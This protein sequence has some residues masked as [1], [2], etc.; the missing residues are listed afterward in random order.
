MIL[1][2]FL[3]SATHHFKWLTSAN[4]WQL[5]K[6]HSIECW[7]VACIVI[8]LSNAI[9]WARKKNTWTDKQTIECLC[10]WSQIDWKINASPRILDH[11]PYNAWQCSFFTT[12]KNP[13]QQRTLT[14]FNSFKSNE[15]ILI[16]AH[17]FIPNKSKKKDN[18]QKMNI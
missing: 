9:L 2:V 17:I 5:N 7:E 6:L 11:L 8:L 15:Y 16:T 1:C 12:K 10:I 18:L 13:Q 14:I 4:I 3:C